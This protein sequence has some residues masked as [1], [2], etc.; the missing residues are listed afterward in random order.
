MEQPHFITELKRD[1]AVLLA[2]S[3]SKYHLNGQLLYNLI[4]FSPDNHLTLYS[5]YL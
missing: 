5:E 3:E 2:L 4:F 1:G